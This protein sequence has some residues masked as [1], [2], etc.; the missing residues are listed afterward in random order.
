M[1]QLNQKLVSLEHM[2]MHVPVTMEDLML[3]I[4]QRRKELV[5]KKAQQI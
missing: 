3:Q 2:M 5:L 4:M 1:H